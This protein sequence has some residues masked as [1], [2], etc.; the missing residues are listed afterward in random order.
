MELY[1]FEY[2]EYSQALFEK[3]RKELIIAR[4]LIHL[5]RYFHSTEMSGHD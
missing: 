3:E 4:D 5:E 1:G 2:D